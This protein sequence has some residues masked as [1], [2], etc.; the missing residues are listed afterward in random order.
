MQRL[1]LSADIKP[2]TVTE[3]GIGVAGDAAIVPGIEAIPLPSG[4]QSYSVS[5][6]IS[7]SSQHVDAAKALIAFLPSPPVKQVLTANGFEVP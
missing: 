7:P 3:I 1:E 2:K 6:G 4:A 5:A